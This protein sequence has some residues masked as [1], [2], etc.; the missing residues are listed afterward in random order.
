MRRSGA[1][2]L[3]LAAL[4]AAVAVAGAAGG[5]FVMPVSDVFAI[6]GRG[7]V[8]TGRVQ[9]GSIAVGDTVCI[10]GGA[11]L[12]VDGIESFRKQLDR[13]RAGA[14]GGLLFRQLTKKDV[15]KGDVLTSCE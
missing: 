10:S 1:F 13:I 7:T 8:V 2:L 11:P 12:A 15:K 4:L 3:L 5:P 9:S 14:H 6:T